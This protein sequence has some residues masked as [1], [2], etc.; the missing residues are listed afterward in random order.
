MARH[1]AWA[2]AALLLLPAR[3]G[4]VEPGQQPGAQ[5]GSAPG[6]HHDDR[7][8][9]KK[10]WIDPQLRSQLG[11]TDQQSAAVDQM[12][13]K[14]LPKLREGHARLETL[15]DALNT[16]IHDGAEES[17]VIPQIE[18]VES[19]R[20]ELNKSRTLM[21]YRM[22]RVLTPDQRAKVK[23]MFDARNTP[24]RGSPSR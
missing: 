9:P 15:E 24:H 14:T 23:A 7:Q 8:G 1:C 16:M 19:T 22:N 12:W 3:S 5:R 21:L 11:I 6:D 13:Q 18:K 20:A 17:V 10:W 4:A 2:I